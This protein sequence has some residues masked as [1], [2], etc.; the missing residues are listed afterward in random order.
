MQKWTERDLLLVL[1]GTS[2]TKVGE[3][4]AYNVMHTIWA[5]S[6]WW[7]TRLNSF[8]L[9]RIPVWPH[10]VWSCLATCVL[11]YPYF[12]CFLCTVAMWPYCL[13][14]CYTHR[15]QAINANRMHK[16][17]PLRE[18]ILS[19][20][21]WHMPLIPALGRQRQADFWVQGQPGVQ[22]EFQ[23]SQGY[24]ENPCL[25]KPKKKT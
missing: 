19:Q 23:D 11:S 18:F 3:Q 22:S 17:F 5:Q 4:Y 24:T 16:W 21:W 20:A 25:E 12:T 15:W 7:G 6:T 13:A 14:Q 2:Q 1:W 8:W 9:L 10:S